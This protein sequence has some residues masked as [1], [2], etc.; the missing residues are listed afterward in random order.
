MRGRH[1]LSANR[2]YRVGCGLFDILLK[3]GICLKSDETYFFD[4]YLT[5]LLF[6]VF[7]LPH[8]FINGHYT[9]SYWLSHFFWV[10]SRLGLNGNLFNDCHLHNE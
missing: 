6:A 4:I 7:L 2:R 9:L 10:E 3:D 1:W 8:A 5:L